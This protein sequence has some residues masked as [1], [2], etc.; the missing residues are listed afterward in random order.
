VKPSAR[1]IERWARIIRDIGLI[2]GVPTLIIIGV[3]LYHLEAEALK[4]RSEALEAQNNFLKETQFDRAAALLE[5]QKKDYEFERERLRKEL[6]KS[7]QDGSASEE[8]VKQLQ[9]QLTEISVKIKAFDT[10]RAFLQSVITE[11]PASQDWGPPDPSSAFQA[12]ALH[13]HGFASLNT[14]GVLRVRSAARYRAQT[15]IK[16]PK[17]LFFTI[18]GGGGSEM[19]VVYNNQTFALYFTEEGPRGHP[20]PPIQIFPPHG[21]SEIRES[22]N[23]NIIV[24][25]TDNKQVNY[26]LDGN[27]I[28][29]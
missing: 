19:I 24:T 13:N 25:G 27:E 26:D 20:I 28:K 12:V 4:A 22:S 18:T 11:E 8:K 9:E 17:G 5:G 2:V 10:S 14:D 29:Q 3:N 15:G 23:G 6:D 1:A 16:S 7:K 21:I